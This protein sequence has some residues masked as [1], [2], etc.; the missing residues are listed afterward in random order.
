MFDELSADQSLITIAN[1]FYAGDMEKTFKNLS[2]VAKMTGRS[3][4]EGWQ[5]FKGTTS[6]CRVLSAQLESVQSGL[7]GYLEAADQLYAGDMLKTFQN[8]S[9]VAK[10][11]GRSLPEG[12]QAFQ[13]TTSEL[14]GCVQWLREK[15]A[16]QPSQ[17]D[18]Q[19]REAFF[20]WSKER[21]G[22]SESTIAKNYSLLTKIV[23]S[24]QAIQAA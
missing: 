16:V 5:Q 15:H 2:A 13:G 4:P 10:M 21:Y 6:E 20:A 17:D 7:D 8:L 14:R 22:K 23:A 19:R 18:E 24:D 11:T 9:A 1:V 12:W 3:L